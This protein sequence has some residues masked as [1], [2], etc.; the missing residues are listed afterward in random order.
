MTNIYDVWIQIGHQPSYGDM[1]GGTSRFSPEG[2][3]RR[4]GSWTKALLAFEAWVEEADHHND[5][6]DHLG[7]PALSRSGTNGRTPSLRLRWKVLERDRFTCGGCGASPATTP[8]TTLH[9]DHV[10]PFSREGR[11]ELDNLQTLCERCNLGKT[12]SLPDPG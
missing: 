3:A 2:Y 1:R 12:N 8:G 9:V 5:A 11:T 7:S 10:V 6:V 4:Y